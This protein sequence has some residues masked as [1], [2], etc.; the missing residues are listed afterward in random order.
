MA[1]RDTIFLKEFLP[2]TQKGLMEVSRHL[3]LGV[4]DMAQPQDW[5]ALLVLLREAPDLPS[6]FPAGKWATIQRIEEMLAEWAHGVWAG[7]SKAPRLTQI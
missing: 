3:E 2:H 1:D 5:A 6:Y 4:E 7:E